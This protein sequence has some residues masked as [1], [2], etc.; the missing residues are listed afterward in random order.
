MSGWV[1]VLDI[2]ISVIPPRAVCVWLGYGV[3]Q[4]HPSVVQ[5]KVLCVL[6]STAAVV[7]VVSFSGTMQLPF[8]EISRCCFYWRPLCIELRVAGLCCGWQ[9]CRKCYRSDQLLYRN[10]WNSVSSGTQ[11]VRTGWSEIAS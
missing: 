2:P 1:M 3:G 4:P 5:P 9:S 8:W 6:L 10:N 7:L 11:E